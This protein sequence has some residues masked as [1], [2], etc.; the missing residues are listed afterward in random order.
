MALEM[1]TSKWELVKRCSM[2]GIMVPDESIEGDFSISFVEGNVKLNDIW[3]ANPVKVKAASGTLYLYKDMPQVPYSCLPKASK[4]MDVAKCSDN[5]P[6]ATPAC[7]EYQ[8]IKWL[9]DACPAEDLPIVLAGVQAFQ[10]KLTKDP[11]NGAKETFFKWDRSYELDILHYL[12]LSRM[13]DV[14]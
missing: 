5:R 8:A 7:Y 4:A 11:S 12:I 9:V 1:P 6:D 10:E 2:L 13:E 3:F 14:Q